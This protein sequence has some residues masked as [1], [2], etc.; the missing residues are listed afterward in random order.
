MPRRTIHR[1]ATRNGKPTHSI[2]PGVTREHGNSRLKRWKV[3]ITTGG[4]RKHVGRFEFEADAAQAYR[5]A[6]LIYPL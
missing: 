5:D 2:Y 6:L 4:K 3:A 1:K